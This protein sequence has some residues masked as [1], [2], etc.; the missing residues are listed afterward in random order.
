LQRLGCYTKARKG[1]D[2]WHVSKINQTQ[3]TYFHSTC[4]VEKEGENMHEGDFVFGE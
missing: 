2:C 1:R 4:V 3:F